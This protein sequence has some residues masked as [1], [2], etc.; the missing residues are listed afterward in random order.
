ML[1]L[2][3]LEKVWEE[4]NAV[5]DQLECND[6]TQQHELDREEFTETC[7]EPKAR[8]DRIISEEQETL[9]QQNHRSLEQRMKLAIV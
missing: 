4:N 9:F 2:Q 8:I 5:Q 6:E 7:C 3:S 1:R